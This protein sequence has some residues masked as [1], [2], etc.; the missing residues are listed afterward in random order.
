M[1]KKLPK[2][3]KIWKGWKTKQWLNEKQEAFCQL[4]TSWDREFFGN[5][6]QTY[7]EVYQPDKTK[8]NWYQTARASTSQI[9][10]NINIIKRINELLDD[11]WLNDV[12][13]D[14]QL[15]FLINQYDDK[16]NK[17]WAIKEYNKLKKRIEDKL[18][19]NV[20]VEWIEIKIE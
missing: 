8:K 4:Y 14:K 16:G 15:L 7:I 3:I 18:D 2:P 11:W 10:T 12:N 6:V 13:V 20:K 9:L 17:L 5:W 1:K 19:L